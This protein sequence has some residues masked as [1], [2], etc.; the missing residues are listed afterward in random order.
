[1]STSSNSIALWRSAPSTLVACGLSRLRARTT[2]R[3]SSSPGERG[4]SSLTKLLVADVAGDLHWLY[5]V[6]VSTRLTAFTRHVLAIIRPDRG[7]T[8]SR[9]SPSATDLVV[10]LQRG[11]VDR[12]APAFAFRDALRAHDASFVLR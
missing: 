6:A 4:R 7:G 5:T 9:P 12:R 1:V 11:E 3:W 10:A 2:A 8:G